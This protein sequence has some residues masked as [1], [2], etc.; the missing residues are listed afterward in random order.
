MMSESASWGALLA[1]ISV[2]VERRHK[3]CNNRYLTIMPAIGSMTVQGRK[4]T[5]WVSPSLSHAAGKPTSKWSSFFHALR[6]L[7]LCRSEI[8]IPSSPKSTHIC[9]CTEPPWCR[10]KLKITNKQSQWIKKGLAWRVHHKIHFPTWVDGELRLRNP[11]L[12]WMGESASRMMFL[13]LCFHL[14][15]WKFYF[16]IN[17]CRM[18]RRRTESNRSLMTSK[19]SWLPLYKLAPATVDPCLDVFGEWFTRQTAIKSL[20]MVLMAIISG[21]TRRKVTH[22]GSFV[23]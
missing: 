2:G 5:F 9:R 14:I 16:K 19:C 1:G 22:D 12:R 20:L 7:I 4:S 17:I 6:W 13:G 10:D 23:R 3:S 15:S 18:S 8:C 11:Y 21:M